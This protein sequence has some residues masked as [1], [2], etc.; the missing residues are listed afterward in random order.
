M[1]AARLLVAVVV[2]L[3]LIAAPVVSPAAGSAGAAT[4]DTATSLSWVTPRPASDVVDGF[5]VGV[6]LAYDDTPYADADRVADLLEDLGVEHVRDDLFLDDTAQYAAMR[7]VAARGIGFDLIAGS[8]ESPGSP[9]DHVAAVAGP[10]R[11]VVESVEGANEWDIFHRL[12][13]GASSDWAGALRDHQQALHAAMEADP[14]TADLPL[15]A[16]SLAFEQ[17]YDELLADGD[18]AAASDVANAHVYPGGTD[19][20]G[21][22]PWMTDLARRLAGGEKPLWVT[23]AGYHDAV[24]TTDG[25]QPVSQA[26]AAA[27]LPRMLAE[28]LAAGVDR[29]YAYELLDE[30]DDPGLTDPEAHF[31]LVRRDYSPK[32]SYLALQ[33]LLA[34]LD[35]G[36]GAAPA[37][38]PLALGV[39]DGVR[40]LLFRSG[41][42]RYQLLLW[43][44]VPVYDTDPASR[45]DVAVASTDVAVDLGRRM[46]ATVSTVGARLAQSPTTTG[47]RVV[48]PLAGDLAV[49][50]LGPPSGRDTVTE[51]SPSPTTTT[52]PA[53]APAPAA[54]SEVVA[55]PGDGTARVSWSGAAGASPDR[56]VVEVSPGSRTVLD[57]SARS[58]TLRGLRNGAAYAV[59]V[60]GETAGRS[61]VATTVRVTPGSVPG[62]PGRLVATRLRSGATKVSWRAAPDHGRPVEKYAVVAGP[63]RLLL[64]GRQHVA[65]L[66]RSVRAREVRVAARNALGWGS[67]TRAGVTRGRR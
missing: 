53:P 49:V 8:P 66:P 43:R 63:R 38:E 50:T 34:L 26:A 37:L 28:H 59:T 41:D 56:W 6:H 33:R 14:R 62:T 24:R 17:H 46:D 64:G 60:T 39:P 22:I 13:A 58:W 21:R 19:P 48:V 35:D 29:V 23:E 57:G 20:R 47:R 7:T 30:R 42:G 1:R 15:L 3:P 18:L 16:P 51:T 61:G 31:G 45:R 40:R 67:W 36:S 12:H 27:Y 4:P 5:G 55:T 2:T 9:A 54:A 65:V 32:P 11:D 52:S 25:H 10:L 44:N